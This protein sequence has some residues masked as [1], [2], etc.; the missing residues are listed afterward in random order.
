MRLAPDTFKDRASDILYILSPQYT[1]CQRFDLI[2]TKVFCLDAAT[3]IER[4]I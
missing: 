2:D 3:N 1:A 4:G